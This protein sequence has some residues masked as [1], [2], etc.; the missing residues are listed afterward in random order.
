MAMAD[1]DVP[2]AALAAKGPLKTPKLDDDTPLASLAKSVMPAAT[3]KPGQIVPAKRAS[4]G[5]TKSKPK[6]A[7]KRRDSS[8]S[9]TS[10]DSSSS[11]SGPRKKKGQQRKPAMKRS[12]TEENMGDEEDNKVSKKK[13]THKEDIVAQL[14]CRWWYSQPYQVCEWPPQEETW[15]LQ[16]LAKKNLR[17]VTIQEWEWTAEEIDGRRKVYELSQFRGL[18]RDSKGELID[19]RPKETCPCFNNFMA[20]DLTV[21]CDMLLTA[22]ENQLKELREKGQYEIE[23]TTNMIKTK[24]AEAQHIQAQARLNHNRADT[25]PLM[26]KKK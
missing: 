26:N 23:K 5:G 11:S 2:L 3:K 1:D 15:Y 21:L 13:R 16:E 8:S 4:V 19:M 25:Q 12:Q 6:G 20:K 7:G 22:Y 17:K 10:S 14:L 9:S 24:M 18:F